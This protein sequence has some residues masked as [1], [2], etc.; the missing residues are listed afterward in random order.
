MAQTRHIMK[1]IFLNLVLFLSLTGAS[2]AQSS[3]MATLSHE[4][5]IS[6]FYGPLALREAHAVAEHG[7]AIAL[8]GGTFKGCD[9]TKAITLRGAGWERDT[10]RNTIPTKIENEITISISDTVPQRLTVE[11][12]YYEGKV[13]IT[14]GLNNATFIKTHFQNG[15]TYSGEG[16]DGS[17][18]KNNSFI[19]CVFYATFYGASYHKTESSYNFINCYLRN[20]INNYDIYSTFTNCAILNCTYID[21]IEYSTLN[22]CILQGKSNKN[23]DILPASSFATNCVVYDS[24]YESGTFTNA[25]PTNKVSTAA[26][27]WAGNG[28]LGALTDEA[29]AKFLGDD[30]TEVGIYGGPFPF[31]S[32]TTNPQITKC[33]VASRSTADG[34]LSIDI[35]VK[36]GE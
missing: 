13:Q 29:K 8:S 6:V 2:F 33:N 1:K 36:A 25:S 27:L 4:G 31:T 35:E 16:Y 34:K 18:Y 26:E 23:Y 12:I 19:Q 24:Y 10:I 30:G 3:M 17:C 22:N 21:E 9:I 28:I 32:T 7:D 15:V 11:G 14:K 5:E 20:G